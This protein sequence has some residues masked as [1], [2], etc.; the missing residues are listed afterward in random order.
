MNVVLRNPLAN[1]PP[2]ERDAGRLCPADYSYAPSVFARAADFAAETLYVAGGLYGNLAA[3]AAIEA[4]AA[5]ETRPPQVVFNG[6]FHWF[7]A[8]PDW[9]AEIEQ[10]V[11]THRS[12]RGN[13][14]TEI[15]RGADVGA[16]CGCAYP[17][18][19]DDG[20]VR[21]SNA[22]L[23]QLARIAPAPARRRLWDL[24]MHLVAQVGALRIGIVH[25]DA[26]SLAGWRFAYDALVRPSHRTWL[27]AVRAASGIDVFASTHTCLAALRDFALEA[28]RLTVVNNGAAGMA[29]FRGMTFGL[30]TPYRHHAVTARAA[31][32]AHPRRRA[33]RR[34]SSRLRP[35]RFSRPLHPAL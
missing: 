15:A 9:F 4:L 18:S 8:E 32:W 24:P 1:S 10:G 20:T 33:H 26:A 23:A 12:L 35:R 2:Q 3:L 27:N 28:G 11:T 16:G 17:E 21:R 30:V 29:N 5:A 14:E 19:V 31:L 7:D 34:H 25:G 13:V 22:I 6:D